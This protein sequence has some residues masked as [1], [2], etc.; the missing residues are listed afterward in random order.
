MVRVKASAILPGFELYECL[1]VCKENIEI[2]KVVC[3]V[4]EDER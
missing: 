1:L 2:E 3:C 4:A